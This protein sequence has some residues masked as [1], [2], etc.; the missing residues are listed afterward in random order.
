MRKVFVLMALFMLGIGIVVAIWKNS[1]EYEE[2][3]LSMPM[4][5]TGNEKALNFRLPRLFGGYVELKEFRGQTPVLLY[6]WATWCPSCREVKLKVD[7][8][9]EEI[10]RGRLAILAINI[11]S[12][13]PLERV[14]DYVK[15]NPF[16]V[17][18]LYD[19]KSEI[20]TT[21]GAFGVPLFVLI[22]REGKIVYWG[23]QL[24]DVKKWLNTTQ[25]G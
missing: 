9:R 10:D 24:P 14:V 3:D 8:L 16:A 22:N 4:T 23:H 7:K 2:V 12:N 6:F 19:R 17:P 25:R 18:V 13:D 21:Y 15:H 5:P 20:S 1:P 11:G